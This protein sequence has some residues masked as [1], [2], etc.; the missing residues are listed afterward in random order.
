M[1]CKS[2]ATTLALLWSNESICLAQ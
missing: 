1:Q 2:N